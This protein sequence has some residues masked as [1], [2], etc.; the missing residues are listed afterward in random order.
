MNGRSNDA[1]TI[2]DCLKARFAAR[3]SGLG[4]GGTG[5]G[6]GLPKAQS[7]MQAKSKRGFKNQE[8][9]VQSKNEVK[10]GGRTIHKKN[11]NERLNKCNGIALSPFPFKLGRPLLTYKKN[12]KFLFSF[13]F[14]FP[15]IFFQNEYHLK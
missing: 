4:G 1:R 3:R 12:L 9:K 15:W 14:F 13:S 6:R 7:S 5:D 11:T 2:G 10:R 8:P